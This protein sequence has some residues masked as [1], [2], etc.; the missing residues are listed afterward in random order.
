MGT[1]LGQSPYAIYVLLG[2][3]VVLA[4]G[5]YVRRKR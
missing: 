1:M 2:V 5:W 3:A 4:V